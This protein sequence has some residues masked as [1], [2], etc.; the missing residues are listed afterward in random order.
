MRVLVRYPVD[1]TPMRPRVPSPRSVALGG[2]GARHLST[3][4]EGR[5]GPH[6]FDAPPDAV[7]VPPWENAVVDPGRARGYRSALGGDPGGRR[8]CETN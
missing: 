1:V 3:L 8:R 4:E 7:D 5:Y 2:V 6:M